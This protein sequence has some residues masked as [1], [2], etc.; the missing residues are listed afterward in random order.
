MEVILISDDEGES[1]PAR[2]GVA[3]APP[4][5]ML[6]VPAFVG[7]SRFLFSAKIRF[8]DLD[9]DLPAKALSS[10]VHKGLRRGADGVGL[11][12]I[13]ETLRAVLQDGRGFAIATNLVNRL[14]CAVMEDLLLFVLKQPRFIEPLFRDMQELVA[15]VAGL[16]GDNLDTC[17]QLLTRIM[18]NLDRVQWRGRYLSFAKML[19]NEENLQGEDDEE[20]RTRMKNDAYN[21]MRVRLDHN[22]MREVKRRKTIAQEVMHELSA[23]SPNLAGLLKMRK[24]NQNAEV[25]RL[26][27]MLKHVG[28]HFKSPIQEYSMVY[29]NNA[30]VAAR[31]LS[32]DVIKEFGILDKHAGGSTETWLETGSVVASASMN[33]PFLNTPYSTLHKKY[34]EVEKKRYQKKIQKKK[35][36]TK[37]VDACEKE[38][39]VGTGAGGVAKRARTG[40]V[41]GRR[42]S[43]GV[44]ERQQYVK[45]L[46]NIP[47]EDA[48]ALEV[49]N[50]YLFDEKMSWGT[51]FKR[52]SAVL[53]TMDGNLVHVKSHESAKTVDLTIRFWKLM[54]DF[55]FKVPQNPRA[56]W[57]KHDL[58]AP[59]VQ[60]DAKPA[61][62]AKPV[63]DAKPAE[64]ASVWQKVMAHAKTKRTKLMHKRWAQSTGGVVLAL[65]SEYLESKMM[66]KMTENEYKESM[67]DV[68]SLGLIMLLNKWLGAGDLNQSNIM[69]TGNVEEESGRLSN[70]GSFVRC[71]CAFIKGSEIRTKFNARGLQTSMYMKFPPTLSAAIKTFIAQE[72][73]T[74]ADWCYELASK[75]PSSRH[76]D[77]RYRLFDDAQ[78][79]QDLKTGKDCAIAA[80]IDDVLESPL[81]YK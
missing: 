45:G 42:A 73:A 34:V 12:V 59:S 64:D 25:R 54:H 30:R 62:D 52:P 11:H 7:D 75:H 66:Q 67:P 80:F 65:E 6:G 43:K 55:G 10:A 23:V 60:Q 57:V 13:V 40:E 5:R 16:T 70:A 24:V 44:A 29:D 68:R 8:D 78:A 50:L 35:K 71:D 22:E 41:Q 76:P 61:E 2:G 53:R 33:P 46:E 37:A 15:A 17:V 19:M 81:S 21:E 48:S 31:P 32:K 74:I 36:R 51:G 9:M 4:V 79:L 20:L 47:Q 38:G 63:E 49:S 69:V 28:D 1:P 58:K 72:H 3:P 77:V 56:L 26:S 39:E 18:G 14:I 27:T